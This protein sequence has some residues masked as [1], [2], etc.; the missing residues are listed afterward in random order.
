MV[1][2]INWVSRCSNIKVLWVIKA[3]LYGGNLAGF[4]LPHWTW[5]WENNI[6]NG[7]DK[8]SQGIQKCYTGISLWPKIDDL[9]RS[10]QYSIT[11]GGCK[12]AFKIYSLPAHPIYQFP[13]LIRLFRGAWITMSRIN[14]SLTL[15]LPS[16]DVLAAGGGSAPPPDVPLLLHLHWVVTCSPS[17]AL[18]TFWLLSSLEEEILLGLGFGE[19]HFLIMKPRS[20][21]SPET[22]KT[23]RDSEL[24]GQTR[25]EDLE[26]PEKKRN[27]YIKRQYRTSE[28]SNKI[29]PFPRLGR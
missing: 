29:L 13:G 24:R 17:W 10:S 2:I 7:S 3:R 4:Y 27:Y 12:T 11:S 26:D 20:T 21:R 9:I 28:N 16:H 18:T 8:A 1:F 19:Q 23:I 5:H 6:R 25:H 22:K 15:R 14:I